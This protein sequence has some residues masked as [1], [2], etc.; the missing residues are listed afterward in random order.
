MFFQ[1]LYQDHQKKS[2][3]L[4]AFIV[5]DRA[6][7]EEITQECFI[8]LYQILKDRELENPGGYLL[9]AVKNLAFDYLKHQKVV[10]RHQQTQ[11]SWDGQGAVSPSAEQVAGDEDYLRFIQQVI[12]ELPPKCRNTLLLNRFFGLTYAEIAQTT[13]IS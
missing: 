5:N 9:Q 12:E 2:I 11:W 4:A 6:V 7:A 10:V 13:G 8:A 1:S 3:D